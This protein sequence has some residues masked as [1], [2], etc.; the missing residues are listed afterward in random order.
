MP[1]GLRPQGDR[2]DGADSLR[3]GFYER[4]ISALP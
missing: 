2:T 3:A 4:L 1:D